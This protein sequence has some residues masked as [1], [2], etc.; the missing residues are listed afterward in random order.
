MIELSPSLSDL[1]NPQTQK[2]H[3]K[4]KTKKP[5]VTIRGMGMIGA[6]VKEKEGTGIM[7]LV[8]EYRCSASGESILFPGEHGENAWHDLHNYEILSLRE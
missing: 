5:P 6:L 7:K 3:S 1:I 2:D 4:K 8:M